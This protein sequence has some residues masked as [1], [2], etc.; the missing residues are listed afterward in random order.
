MPVGAEPGAST[1]YAGEAEEAGRPP[2]RV[3]RLERK[4]I[5][6]KITTFLA[7]TSLCERR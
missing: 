1:F 4:S 3:A 6:F 5:S 7:K 2:R